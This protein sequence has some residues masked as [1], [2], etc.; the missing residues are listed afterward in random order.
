ML[1]DLVRMYPSHAEAFTDSGVDSQTVGAFFPLH[2][3]DVFNW[4]TE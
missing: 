3:D 4:N 1:H 2:V